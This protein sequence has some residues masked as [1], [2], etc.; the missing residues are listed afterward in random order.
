MRVGAPREKAASLF[1]THANACRGQPP[2]PL[3]CC[4]P[5]LLLLWAACVVRGAC[6]GIRD[7][8]AAC[9]ARRVTG[10]C[11]SVATFHVGSER[12]DVGACRCS[13][14]SSTRT[15]FGRHAY[16]AASGTTGSRA[17]QGRSDADSD[18]SEATISTSTGRRSITAP[19]G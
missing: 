9:G 18:A 13:L 11:N 4:T 6:A 8:R 10:S 3:A 5:A 2:P 12:V 14:A 19:L 7:R 17:N 15:V 16:L 1:Q